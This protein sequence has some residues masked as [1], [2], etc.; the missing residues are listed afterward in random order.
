MRADGLGR[1]LPRPSPYLLTRTFFDHRANALAISP[2]G[3]TLVLNLGARTDHGESYG[4]V[5]EEG[6]TV[7]LLQIPADASDTDMM[8]GTFTS[9]RS[10]LGLVLDADSV[11]ADG[12]KGSACVVSFNGV[13][14]EL[15]GRMNG[16][17]ED[18]IALDLDKSNGAYTVSTRLVASGFDH[19]V[20][21]AMVGNVI[22]VI[23]FGSYDG[24]DGS[25]SV[26]AVTVPRETETKVSAPADA[27]ALTLSAAPNPTQG[28]V[29]LTYSLPSSTT[30]RLEIVDA[31]GRTVR[32]VRTGEAS[33]GSH[34]VAFST[35]ELPNGLYLVRL[36]AD[37]RQNVQLLTVLR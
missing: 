5:R 25:R 26:H 17:S 10:P 15:L 8:L 14:D 23:E 22:Y 16:A 34:S 24:S 4:G 11:L 32:V 29:T 18:L 30:V 27:E 36:T 35:D 1:R 19:P 13:D 21:A 37:G 2:D 6:L 28:A 12:L 33:I 7:L 3:S 20:D 9:H 31:L